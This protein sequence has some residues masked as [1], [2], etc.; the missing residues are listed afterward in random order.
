MRC[1]PRAHTHLSHT[2]VVCSPGCHL[3][4]DTEVSA[5]V[6]PDYKAASFLGLWDSWIHSQRS[7]IKPKLETEALTGI[8][9]NYNNVEKADL[10]S[11]DLVCSWRSY[12]GISTKWNWLMKFLVWHLTEL[13]VTREQGPGK[14]FDT[15]YQCI[16]IL[17][18]DFWSKLACVWIKI[19]YEAS[20]DE[21]MRHVVLCRWGGGANP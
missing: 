2:V 21:A 3:T 7:I 14:V 18:K 13:F 15:D 19:K 16:F 6:S 4:S 10:L 20:V 11:G 9:K 12:K 8:K 5:A 1:L 17:M